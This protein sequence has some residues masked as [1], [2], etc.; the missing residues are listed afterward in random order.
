M[1][2][3]H[4]S[5][6]W[7]LP[8]VSVVTAEGS[9]CCHSKRWHAQCCT[10]SLTHGAAYFMC[11]GW[12]W[13]TFM[14]PLQS[15]SMNFP[16]MTPCLTLSCLQSFVVSQRAK[17][18]GKT[19]LQQQLQPGVCFIQICRVFWLF[20]C[21]WMN[22]SALLLDW[23]LGWIKVVKSLREIVIRAVNHT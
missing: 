10:H 21:F 22:I 19:P 13:S 12:Y 11:C 20:F 5:E 7:L 18:G 3:I 4:S 9:V 1:S 15:M 16:E 23:S 14:M 17:K 2:H 6:L 8:N